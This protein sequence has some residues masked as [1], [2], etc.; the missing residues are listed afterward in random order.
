MKQLRSF[1][2]AMTPGTRSVLHDVLQN[3]SWG[4]RVLCC[5]KTLLSSLA[6]LGSHPV[7][8]LLAHES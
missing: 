5:C 7:F 6:Y 1:E 2:G 3:L 4:G 8:W